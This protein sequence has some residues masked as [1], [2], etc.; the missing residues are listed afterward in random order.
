MLSTEGNKH[1]LPPE[2][3]R[4]P[5]LQRQSRLGTRLGEL[6]SAARLLGWTVSL[7]LQADA[8]CFKVFINLSAGPVPQAVTCG[9]P[10]PGPSAV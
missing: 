5:G 6:K 7:H 2:G 8:R 3:N 4:G 1:A 9:D 10:P